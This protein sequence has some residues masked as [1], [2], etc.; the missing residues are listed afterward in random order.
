[1]RFRTL[2]PTRIISDYELRKI[3]DV[4][5]MWGL[6]GWLEQMTRTTDLYQT[7]E[8]DGH[9][10]VGVQTGALTVRSIAQASDPSGLVRAGRRHTA[11]ACTHR[12]L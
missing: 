2:Y 6:R 10:D 9:G 11:R 5:V 1:M 7:D 3:A 8:P 4:L 12:G